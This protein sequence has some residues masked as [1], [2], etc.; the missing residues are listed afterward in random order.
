MIDNRHKSKSTTSSVCT[1]VL[2]V[3]S[4]KPG[5]AYVARAPL[6]ARE[7]EILT[8]ASHG[9]TGLEMALS[10]AITERTV[11]FHINNI[12]EKLGV[13]NKTHAVA[14]ALRQGLIA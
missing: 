7:V 12:I 3:G 2:A 1:V 5:T 9:K 11:A 14:V 6:S 13:S 4:E 8:L 10:L